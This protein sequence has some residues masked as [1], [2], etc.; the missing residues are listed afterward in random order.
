[1][2]TRCG[3]CVVLLATGG[4]FAQNR[5]GFVNTQP[6]I[7]TFPS[8]IYPGGTSALPG[9]QRTTG[10]VVNPAGG[11]QIAVPGLPFV[12]TQTFPSR[13]GAVVSGQ[14]FAFSGQTV[15]GFGNQ[16]GRGRG[17]GKGNGSIGKGFF[18]NGFFGNGFGGGGWGGGGWAYPI[19]VPVP[20]Y[21]PSYYGGQQQQQ[22]PPNIVVVYPPQQTATPVMIDNP[23][24]GGPAQG[25]G[26]T[27]MY[28]P[29]APPSQQTGDPAPSTEASHYL[30][31]FKDHTIYSAIAY[32][33]DGDT[34]H[35]FTT[36]NTHNQ[37]SLSLIDRALTQ[38]LNKESGLEVR[39][40]DSATK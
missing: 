40:P 37:V 13:L 33:V 9:V 28:Q 38:R 20:S 34:L 26:P 35:Y 39:L 29:A 31:A 14:Q 25:P 5:S 12:N 15:G 10:S 30:I 4:L 16:F 36:G 24:A 7:R 27:T 22:A 8:V 23:Y 1:M 6:I 21:D 17:N 11:V 2:T 3:L 19:Y 18:G 32:W